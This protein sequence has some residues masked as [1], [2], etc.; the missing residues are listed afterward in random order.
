MEQRFVVDTDMQSASSNGNKDTNASQ[1]ENKSTAT[2][3]QVGNK[4]TAVAQPE[5]EALGNGNQSTA[6]DILAQL[7]DLEAEVMDMLD[8]TNSYEPPTATPTPAPVTSAPQPT[9]PSP[10]KKEE[11]RK[12]SATVNEPDTGKN[13]P[14]SP[15]SKASPS[16]SSSPHQA[17][18]EDL[19]L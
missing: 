11:E 12:K 6:D 10:Q 19:C 8:D 14:S 3:E 16:V 4:A 13:I 2:T 7:A 15:S 18:R 1:N 9:P 17:Y 5:S